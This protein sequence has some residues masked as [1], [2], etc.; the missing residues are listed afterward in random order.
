MEDIIRH[1]ESDPTAKGQIEALLSEN[2]DAN[3]RAMLKSVWKEEV[4][5][6]KERQQFFNDQC[7]CGE[8]S[9]FCTFFAV[10]GYKG[11]RCG[12]VSYRIGEED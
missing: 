3:S 6:S 11:N 7:R 8:L 1:I 5:M 12:T 9:G 10:S 2:G 4:S